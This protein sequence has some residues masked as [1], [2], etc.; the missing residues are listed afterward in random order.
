MNNYLTSDENISHILKRIKESDNKSGLYIRR[1][2][3][4]ELKLDPGKIGFDSAGTF[5]SHLKKKEY[6]QNTPYGH[7][8]YGGRSTISADD[9]IRVTEKGEAFIKEMVERIFKNLQAPEKIK[10]KRKINWDKIKNNT[11]WLFSVAGTIIIILIG[12][13]ALGIF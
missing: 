3:H 10:D 6:I 9:E 12:L 8:N 7:W 1:M 2:V 11:T 13:K 5:L 4:A